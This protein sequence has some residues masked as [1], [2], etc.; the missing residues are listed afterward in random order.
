MKTL[1]YLGAFI[2]GALAGAAVGLLAAP[3]KGSET[4][5]KLTSAVKEFCDKH[6]IKLTRKQVE[7]LVDDVTDLDVDY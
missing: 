2:G 6:D 3:D 4:R 5:A 7:E 1:G